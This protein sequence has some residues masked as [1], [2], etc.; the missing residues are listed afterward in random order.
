MHK[1]D[2]STLPL[3]FPRVCSLCLD[4][5]FDSSFLVNSFQ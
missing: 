4:Y 5:S 3:R 1:Q 2:R